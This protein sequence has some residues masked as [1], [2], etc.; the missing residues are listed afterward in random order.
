MA[1]GWLFVIEDDRGSVPVRVGLEEIA[2]AREA[3]IGAVG[4]FGAIVLEKPLEDESLSPGE[5]QTGE[6][7]TTITEATPRRLN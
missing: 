6:R 7:S 1:K 3:A 2:V 4:G 5:V